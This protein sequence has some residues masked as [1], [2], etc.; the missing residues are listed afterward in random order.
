MAFSEKKNITQP[1]LRW[2]RLDNA[3]KVYPAARRRDWTNV[4]RVSATLKEQVDPAVLQ[5]ALDVTAP[6]FPSICA[7]LRRGVF[8]YY[9]QQLKESPRVRQESSYPLTYM[10]REE[11]RESP[12]RVIA[13][14]NRIAVEIFH[15]LTDGNGAMVFLK[16]LVAEYLQQK[17]GIT[18]PAEC[19]IL[20]RQEAPTEAELEDSFQKH[21]GAIC[22]SRKANDSWQVRGTPETGGFLHV[23]C[24]RLPVETVRE[25]AHRH[26]VSITVFLGAVML[27][28]LQQ[29]QAER[30]PD[31]NLRKSIK[32][33]IPINLRR[34]FGSN[35]LRNF[36]L[37]TTPEI[38]PKLGDYSFEEICSIIHH[39]MGLDNNPKHMSTMIA[40]NVLSERILAVRLMPLFIKN[41]CIKAVY[42]AVGERK[43]C[44]SLS[45]LG[46]VLLPEEMDPYVRRFDFILGVQATSPYNCGVVAYKDQICVNFIRKIREPL[47]EARFHQ[48]LRDMGIPVLA[49]SN[50]GGR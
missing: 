24:L 40:A 5:A 33:L 15:A 17:Y 19:G 35:T 42:S 25:A 1:R 7:R 50:L 26:H 46:L 4:F 2:L 3:A 16:S 34:M 28:A 18:V 14:Q 8:W 9:L 20:D 31:R 11:L 38:Q 43:S 13:Y 6:R 27:L 30:V 29:L 48:I 10:S 32:L 23:T 45:N 36:V 39:Q 21:A 41:L 37:Y 49:E 12:V 22:A 44:L 47:L